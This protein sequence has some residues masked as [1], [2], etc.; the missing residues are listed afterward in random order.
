LAVEVLFSSKPDLG[1]YLLHFSM[2]FSSSKFIVPSIMKM[3]GLERTK[4]SRYLR[5]GGDGEA[6]QP[7]KG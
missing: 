2:P 7:E 6:V 1:E 5:W 3:F 4:G